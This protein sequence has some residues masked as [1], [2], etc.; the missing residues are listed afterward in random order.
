[1]GKNL[2]SVSSPNVVAMILASA[3][4]FFVFFLQ[5]DEDCHCESKCLFLNINKDAWLNV[6][7][8]LFFSMN[9]WIA[10]NMDQWH[11]ALVL[12]A[13]GVGYARDWYG[14]RIKI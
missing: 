2:D 1:M 10:L 12:S 9:D 11:S 3:F 4:H 6:L 5:Y 14:E 7:I 13:I 8:V